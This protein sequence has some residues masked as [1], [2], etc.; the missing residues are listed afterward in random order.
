MEDFSKLTICDLINLWG[1]LATPDHSI[2]PV[3]SAYDQLNFPKNWFVQKRHHGVFKHEKGRPERT[4][5]PR[6]EKKLDR[7]RTKTSRKG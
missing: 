3:T 6:D 5:T 1:D 2:F 7:L 4:K